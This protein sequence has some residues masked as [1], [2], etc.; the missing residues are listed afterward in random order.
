MN[1]TFALI[2]E[3]AIAICAFPTITNAAG[4]EYSGVF[5]ATGGIVQPSEKPYR[6]EICLNGR[7]KFQPFQVPADFMRGESTPPILSPPY[8]NGWDV[9][10]IKIPSPW[11]VNA[12]GTGHKTGDPARPY[13]PGSN[14]FPGYPASWIAVEMGWLKRT[15]TVPKHWQGKRL[16]LHFE[17][18]SGDC[19]VL[20]NG[21]SAGKHF[22]SWL[23][24]DLDIT[25][26][27][28]K[29]GENVLLVGIRA[30]SLFNVQSKRYAKMRAPYPTGSSTERLV[31]IWQDVFL[32][33]VPSVRIQDIFIQPQVDQDILKLEVT[34]MNNTGVSKRVHVVG[35]IRPW[36]RTGKPGAPAIRLPTGDLTVPA[37]G[38]AKLTLEQKV[39]GRLKPWALGSPNL[40]LSELTIQANGKTVDSHEQRFGWR[41]FIIKG[42]DLLLNGKRIQLTGDLLHPFGPFI[43]S[44]A[45]VRA[46]YQ[47]V[48]G[49]GGNSVRLHAQIHPRH[50]L[51]MADEMGLAVLDETALFGSSVM[52]NFEE[53]IAWQRFADHYDGLVMRDRNHPSVFGWGF[54]NEL[55]AI[56]DLNLVTKEDSDRWYKQLAELGKRSLK[57]DPTR[58]WISCDGDEDLRG[59]LP[60]WSRH[61]GHGMSV[62]R[63]PNI[64]K[65]LMI[66]ESGGTYYARPEQLAVFNGERAYEN[67]TGRSE[68]LGIDVYQNIVKMARP[69]LAFYSASETTWFGMEHLPLGYHDFSRMPDE[70]DG[71]FL[72]RP[73]HEGVPGIQPERI[74]PYVCTLNPGWDPA[75]PLFKPLP[76]YEAQKA[77]LAQPTPKTWSPSI[78]HA[79][80]V[81]SQTAPSIEHVSFL[82][83]EHGELFRRMTALGAPWQ[84]EADSF[85]MVDLD[86]ITSTDVLSIKTLL[87]RM[88]SL[89]GTML[90][91]LGAGKATSEMLD[92]MLPGEVR[93]LPHEAT[94]LSPNREHPWAKTFSLDSLYFA[95]D[96]ANRTIQKW[97]LTGS[98]VEQGRVALQASQTDWSLFNNAPEEAKCGAVLLYEQLKKAS[99][100]SLVDV[101]YGK[102]H[103]A[104]CSLDYRV[105][106]RSTDA[107]WRNL[108]INMGLKLSAPQQMITP[109]FEGNVLVNTRSIGRIAAAE[110]PDAPA[111]GMDL[112]GLKWKSVTAPSRDRFIFHEMNQSGPQNAYAVY[113]SFWIKSPRGLEDLLGGGPDAPRLGMLCY[114]AEA[115]KLILNGKEITSASTTPVDYRTLYTFER[116]PLKKGWN[117]FLIKVTSNTLQGDKPGTLAVRLFCN[118]DAYLHELDSAIET[119]SETSI[120]K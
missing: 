35:Q 41:Q 37:N 112:G 83:K 30:H 5:A 111:V 31:G 33:A 81:L 34:V 17:A 98:L 99:V 110:A 29:S 85:T 60:V 77:A 89:G 117:H 82:G 104:L 91:M 51:E 80:P 90:W 20:V 24:F 92:A 113:F 93:L 11:N 105:R 2:L 54:G 108:L 87:E 103:I 49:F 57:L 119:G 25:G 12:W 53:P 79:S 15:F 32:L 67:Y 107:F 42:K 63:I 109:A 59:A 100:T 70:Q 58:T 84:K 36:S 71:V 3:S 22:D 46:W 116:L 27:V 118:D 72:T 1:K 74:P 9:T 16:F 65:P 120:Y 26:L 45:Y 97:G 106:S 48:Q 78:S 52:L 10:P 115:C 39:A 55:F 19:Q 61:F 7:W 14:Y 18:V 101:P 21:V 75:L 28:H 96:G 6:Q 47:A 68:S 62:D 56:F 23:P 66:G 4:V 69:L 86:T 50:Y 76:M 94:A 64:N 13:D 114:V 38:S 88:K 95:E 40:Y 102:G 8:E 44:P 73:F 43:L